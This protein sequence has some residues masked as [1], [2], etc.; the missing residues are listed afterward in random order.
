MLIPSDSDNKFKIHQGLLRSLSPAFLSTSEGGWAETTAGCHKFLPSDIA[1][2]TAGS[3]AVISQDVVICF[4]AWAYVGDYQTE[5]VGVTSLFLAAEYPT[6]MSKSNKRGKKNLTLGVVGNVGWGTQE[7]IPPTEEQKPSISEITP[8]VE[9]L[10]LSPPTKRP[11]HLLLNIQIYTFATI[12][13]IE[14]L[15]LV[16]QQKIIRYL[17]E[18]EGRRLNLTEPMLSVL[19]YAVIYLAEGDTLLDWLARYASWKLDLFRAEKERWELLIKE[20]EWKL[21][22]LLMKYVASSE[23]SPF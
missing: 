11:D 20:D 1:G 4:I 21:S 18:G 12:Y 23:E 2:S 6:V 10:T 15:R 14:P 16:A 9:D 5:A 17:Q 13:L 22:G 8:E 19:E 3:E 7:I